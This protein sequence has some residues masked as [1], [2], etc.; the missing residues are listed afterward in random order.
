MKLKST[1]MFL[2]AKDL[3]EGDKVKFTDEGKYEMSQFK[4]KNGNLKELM[5]IG[6]QL[7]NGEQKVATVNKGS[8]QWLGEHLGDETSAWVG[9]EVP[10]F[11]VPQ[12]VGGKWVKVIY[13]GAIPD[14]DGEASPENNE[15][16]PGDE[17]PEG[18]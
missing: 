13:F 3:H 6:V 1:S 8:Q 10:V 17:L 7:P 14:T 11:T 18:F 16:D 15:Q 12:N 2:S 9:K 5:K 4:D